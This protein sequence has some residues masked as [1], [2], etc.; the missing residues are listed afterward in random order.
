MLAVLQCSHY[1]PEKRKKE[2]KF[3][4]KNENIFAEFL[5]KNMV[6]NIW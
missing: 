1:K 3:K 6:Q 4:K 2:M 5:T